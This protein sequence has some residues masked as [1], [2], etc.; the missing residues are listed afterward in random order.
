[1]VNLKLSRVMLPLQY[2]Y[3]CKIAVTIPKCVYGVESR[4]LTLS[5]L[6]ELLRV[7]KHQDRPEDYKRC[8]I[9]PEILCLR[10]LTN[11]HTVIY[12]INLACIPH[13]GGKCRFRSIHS[14]PNLPRKSSKFQFEPTLSY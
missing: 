13:H 12:Y 9:L 10:T 7:S 11:L 14:I 4:M 6:L 5:M 3:S 1:M 8:L 2:R